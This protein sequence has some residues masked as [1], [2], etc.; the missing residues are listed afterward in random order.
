[1]PVIVKVPELRVTLPVGAFPEA[2]C[3]V[4]VMIAVADCA[5]VERLVVTVIVVAEV[6]LTV[7]ADDVDAVNVVAVE[8]S[9][10]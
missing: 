2:A 9:P 5:T 4:A 7:V 10:P 8:L 1:L 6:T 3:M